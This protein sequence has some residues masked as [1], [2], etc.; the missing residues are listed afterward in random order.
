MAPEAGAVRAGRVLHSPFR[1]TLTH[2]DMASFCEALP[3][4]G[5]AACGSTLAGK[6]AFGERT[7]CLPVQASIATDHSL[8]GSNNTYFFPKTKT[9]ELRSRRIRLGVCQGLCSWL[10]DSTFPL[11]PHRIFL[12]CEKRGQGEGRA[13]F[14]SYR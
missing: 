11:H 6:R 4:K 14:H 1:G 7:L 12:K 2:G 9:E 13:S 3:S 5:F 8:G 10:R